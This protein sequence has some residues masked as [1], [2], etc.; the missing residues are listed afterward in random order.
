VF[1]FAIVAVAALAAAEPPRAETFGSSS[2]R[3]AAFRTPAPPA[4]IDGRVVSRDRKPRANV[5]VRARLSETGREY[6]VVTDRDGRFVVAGFD[7]DVN[8]ALDFRDDSLPMLITSCSVGLTRRA[9]EAVVTVLLDAWDRAAALPDV[10][11]E[12]RPS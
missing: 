5:Q 6:T 1:T 4:R 7:A 12:G 9:P 10:G 2:G 3:C 11:C 8:V